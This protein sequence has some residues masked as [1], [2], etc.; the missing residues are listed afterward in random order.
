MEKI[1]VKNVPGCWSAEDVN[2]ARGIRSAAAA[3]QKETKGAPARYIEEGYLMTRSRMTKSVA[4]IP[5]DTIP[6]YY[7][8]NFNDNQ[9]YALASADTRMAP[10]LCLVEKGHFS[11]D[12]VLRNPGQIALL[13]HIETDYRMALGLPIEDSRGRIITAEQYGGVKIPLELTREESI[14]HG[15]PYPGDNPPNYIYYTPLLSTRWGQGYPFNA[16][17]PV[18]N[19]TICP[20]GC[21]NIANAQIMNYHGGETVIDNYYV[22]WSEVNTIIDRNTGTTLGW[23]MLQNFLY[24]T[25]IILNANIQPSG[26][27]VPPS[28]LPDFLLSLGY[29]SGGGSLVD[30]DVYQMKQEIIAGYPVYGQGFSHISVSSAFGNSVV[31]YQNGHAWVYDGLL[32]IS[33]SFL[34]S[35]NTE[36]YPHCNLG[37]GGN[38]DGYYY[39]GH[40]NTNT[41]PSYSLVSKEQNIT[42][43]QLV[44]KVQSSEGTDYYYKYNMQMRYGIRP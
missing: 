41:G 44:T 1:A 9:G 34:F 15:Q 12:S 35:S 5:G 17:M 14:D 18:I 29:T 7:V 20:V 26:T 28:L 16:L 3:L 8:F 30:L 33:V 13:S 43:Q 24:K 22:D 6:P 42:N 37:W 19:D 32:E 2:S 31:S 23:Q 39:L 4:N 25:A 38:D 40:V 27:S 10:L 11:P 36:Y 21:V